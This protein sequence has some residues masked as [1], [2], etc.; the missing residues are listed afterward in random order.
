M[1]CGKNLHSYP[2]TASRIEEETDMEKYEEMILE[3]IAF[4][5]E[6]IIVT[7]GDQD[8]DDEDV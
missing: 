5:G 1:R 6:D 8:T 3:I 2:Q 7:S 4:Q